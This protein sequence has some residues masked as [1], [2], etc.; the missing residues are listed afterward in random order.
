[1]CSSDALAHAALA[2]GA[3]GAFAVVTDARRREVYWATYDETGA[4]TGG[5]AVDRPDRVAAELAAAG[6]SV[7]GPATD[8]YPF[9][10][11]LP[12]LPLSAG[13]LAALVAGG[14]A[15]AA[16][17]SAALPPPP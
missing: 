17:G 1:M 5:P 12:S 10:A 13:A 11:V 7:L 3:G 14:S 8:L 16:A 6:T 4:R 2:G 9:E 15:R